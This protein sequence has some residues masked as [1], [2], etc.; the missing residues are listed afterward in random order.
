MSNQVIAALLVFVPLAA[1]G[2]M[3]WSM[4]SSSSRRKPAAPKVVPLD[5]QDLA[6]K[7]DALVRN[8]LGA[9]KDPG[10]QLALSSRLE[11]SQS[12]A[13]EERKLVLLEILL[14]LD[15]VASAPPDPRDLPAA[16]GPEEAEILTLLG[17]PNPLRDAYLARRV[18]ELLDGRLRSVMGSDGTKRAFKNAGLLPEGVEAWEQWLKSGGMKAWVMKLAEG[19]RTGV[20]PE[21]LIALV[22]TAARDLG[23]RVPLACFPRLLST[24]PDGCLSSEK[25]SSE[26]REALWRNFLQTRRE[27]HDAQDQL[28]RS[29]AVAALA[30]FSASMAHEINNPLAGVMGLLQIIKLEL[31]SRPDLAELVAGAEGE[32]KRIADIVSHLSRVMDTTGSGEICEIDVN[33]LVDSALTLVDRQAAASDIRI[34]RQLGQ[35]GMLLGDPQELRQALLHLLLNG[36]ASME[37]GGGVLT[38]STRTEAGKVAVSI[39]DTG[40]GLDEM[41]LARLDEPEQLDKLFDPLRPDRRQAGTKWRGIKAAQRIAFSLHGQIQV[42]SAPGQGSTFT[43]TLPTA[44]SRHASA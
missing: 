37:E 43:L 12:M 40:P 32:A 14:D 1:T 3:I 8:R 6:G 19:A 10:A 38:V 27:L 24:F 22:E 42:A 30:E 28:L 35:V 41:E 5:R 25:S 21:R 33:A 34:E 36:L 17:H 4:Y 9:V 15:R 13:T 20:G 23:K 29:Q 16:N 26:A 44:D 39:H 11:S 2:W 7:L 18:L 31:S